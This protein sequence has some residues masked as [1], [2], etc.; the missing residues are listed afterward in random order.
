M[1]HYFTMV[2]CV[3]KYLQKKPACE[4]C[5]SYWLW[6]FLNMQYS[7]WWILVAVQF[8]HIKCPHILRYTVVP[9]VFA[10][11]FSLSSSIA[12]PG[13]VI[14]SLLAVLRDTC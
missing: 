6:E 7:S 8:H 4:I 14:F 5:K 3:L 9:S 2:M 10:V 11:R 12:G 13:H 1:C